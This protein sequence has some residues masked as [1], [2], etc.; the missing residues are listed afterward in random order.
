[1]RIDMKNERIRL[2]S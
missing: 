2:L 1:M